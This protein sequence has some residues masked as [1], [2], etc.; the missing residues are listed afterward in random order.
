MKLETERRWERGSLEELCCEGCSPNPT[1]CLEEGRPAPRG[2]HVRGLS[3]EP[4]R[5][6]GRAEEP[7]QESLAAEPPGVL[8]GG[9]RRRQ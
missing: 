4:G 5:H 8:C 6:L 2:G 1:G 7:S 9:M 3:R